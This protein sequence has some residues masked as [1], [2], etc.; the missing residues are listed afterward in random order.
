MSDL[1]FYTEKALRS[2][3]G[4]GQAEAYASESVIHTVYIDG[5][6]ISNIETKRESGMMVRIAD[7]GR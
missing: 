5:S 7:G 3:E 4:Y 6:R 2:V 1:Q